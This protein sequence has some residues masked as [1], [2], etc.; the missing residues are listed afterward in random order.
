MKA[1]QRFSGHFVQG[2]VD[3]TVELVKIQHDPPNSVIFTF[4]IP[5]PHIDF[6]NLDYLNYV[7][8][9]GYV[10]LD[11]TSLTVISVDRGARTFSV[12]L[13]QYTQDHVVMPLKKEGD[14]VNLEVDQIGKYVENVVVAMLSSD[15]GALDNHHQE[16]VQNKTALSFR[17]MVK[18]VV[19]STLAE[20]QS[21]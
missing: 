20:Q 10:C 7:I 13:V 4:R 9:K 16:G 3:T 2:H 19:Q 1:G 18:S 21:I 5:L 12:M 6:D 11:G 17:A 8:P 14:A 15:A